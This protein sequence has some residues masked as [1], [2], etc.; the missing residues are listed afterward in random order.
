VDTTNKIQGYVSKTEK[1]T[2]ISTILLNLNSSD[3]QSKEMSKYFLSLE[4]EITIQGEKMKA[5]IDIITKEF[6][7]KCREIQQYNTD[8]LCKYKNKLQSLLSKLNDKLSSCK[9][10]LQSK[11]N[12]LIID[13]EMDIKKELKHPHVPKLKTAKFTPGQLPAEQVK[14]GFGCIS[15]QH[16]QKML[17][18]QE[19]AAHLL[20]IPDGVTEY[21]SNDSTVV[22]VFIH[23]SDITSVEKST[24]DNKWVS[25]EKDKNISLVSL[26]GLMKQKL[27]VHDISVSPVTGNLWLCCRDCTVYE[28]SGKIPNKRF[29]TDSPPWSLCLTPDNI[30]SVGTVHNITVY[31]TTGALLHTINNSG[32]HLELAPY[33]ITVCTST[34][35]V[36]VCDRHLSCYGGKDKP[37][38]SVFNYKLRLRSV[39]WP[40]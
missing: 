20:P 32:K 26:Q 37:H 29:T 4:D 18:P 22:L 25:Y 34:G 31:S 11:N 10:I 28:V 39:P 2:E 6:V 21:R 38:V 8:I 5:E 15:V 14:D 13:T 1:Q 19:V 3:D 35:D 24:S 36:A 30:V 9:E 33:H 16:R 27:N 12:V 23:S 40:A 7:D 17:A